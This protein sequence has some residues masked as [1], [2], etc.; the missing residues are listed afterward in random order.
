MTNHIRSKSIRHAQLREKLFGY[1]DTVTVGEIINLHIVAP[2]MR[3][4]RRCVP[5]TQT[6]SNIMRERADYECL[7]AGQW[8]RV[9]AH[10]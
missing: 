1:L 3:Y 10:E 9:E 5:S 6:V 7:G 2:E 8:K 4:N